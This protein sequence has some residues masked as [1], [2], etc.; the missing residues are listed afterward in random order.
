PMLNLIHFR[1]SFAIATAET[2]HSQQSN[3]HVSIRTLRHPAPTETEPS[4]RSLAGKPCAEFRAAS[5]LPETTH[6]A[7]QYPLHPQA[8]SGTLLERVAAGVPVR[9]AR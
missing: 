6:A 4:F 1:T 5:Q 9:A 3:L 8:R 7:A 2:V